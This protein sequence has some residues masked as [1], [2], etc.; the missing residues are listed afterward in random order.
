MLWPQVSFDLER[1]GKAPRAAIGPTED[2]RRQ[3][4]EGWGVPGFPV[5]RN[6]DVQRWPHLAIVGSLTPAAPGLG[7]GLVAVPR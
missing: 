5:P 6:P 7:T 4:R 1:E 2:L 3:A